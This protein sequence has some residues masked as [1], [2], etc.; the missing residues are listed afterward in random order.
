MVFKCGPGKVS[1]NLSI[2]PLDEIVYIAINLKVH[3]IQIKA[4]DLNGINSL[5]FRNRL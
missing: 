5:C 3:N 4:S 1:L 2:N